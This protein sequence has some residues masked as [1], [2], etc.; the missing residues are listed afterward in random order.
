MWLGKS[1]RVFNSL[2]TISFAENLGSIE[3]KTAQQL[4]ENMPSIKYTH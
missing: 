1:K 4:Y 2:A 3:A